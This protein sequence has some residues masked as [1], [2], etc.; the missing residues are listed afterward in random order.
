MGEKGKQLQGTFNAHIAP[1]ADHFEPLFPTETYYKDKILPWQA[2]P[3]KKEKLKRK[4]F[5]QGV[6]AKE[7]VKGQNKIYIN[8]HFL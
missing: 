7:K 6:Q 5:T 4:I 2:N 8:F 3:E 1:H